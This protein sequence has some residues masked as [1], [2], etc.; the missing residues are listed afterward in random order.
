MGG[1]QLAGMTVSDCTTLTL[2]VKKVPASMPA[3]Q[4]T[5]HLPPINLCASPTSELWCDK[6]QRLTSHAS[7]ETV[8]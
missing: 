5:K 6:K 8:H 1:F 7:E 2:L 4:C 3:E